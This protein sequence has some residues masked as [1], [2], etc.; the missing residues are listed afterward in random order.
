M[1]SRT[2]FFLG[3]L[4]L[5]HSVLGLIDKVTIDGIEPDAGLLSGT[6]L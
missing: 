2:M 3:V 6:F 5:L 1:N 4:A